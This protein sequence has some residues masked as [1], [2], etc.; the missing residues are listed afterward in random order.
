MEKKFFTTALYS[1]QMYL[2]VG[3]LKLPWDTHKWTDT[4]MGHIVER[5]SLPKPLENGC[6]MA[7]MF[8][9]RTREIWNA[10]TCSTYVNCSAKRQQ[11]R[12]HF[13][14]HHRDLHPD[15]ITRSW[16]SPNIVF[17][18]P[19]SSAPVAFR[20]R[21]RAME[22]KNKEYILSKNLYQYFNG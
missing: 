11:P 21:E 12:S 1:M 20:T 7:E 4:F 5:I 2:P 3:M 9:P 10:A 16:T 8:I 6:P 14:A 19:A 15:Y 17:Y 13:A 18:A 22:R